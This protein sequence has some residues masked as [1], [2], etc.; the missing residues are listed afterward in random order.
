VRDVGPDGDGGDDLEPGGVHDPHGAHVRTEH[1]GAVADCSEADAMAEPLAT[2]DLGVDGRDDAAQRP[3]RGLERPDRPVGEHR[4]EQR[5]AVGAERRGLG[6]AAEVD[7]AGDQ[8]AR[9]DVVDASQR[10]SRQVV[11][12]E[13]GD[14]IGVGRGGEDAAV[15][16]FEIAARGQIL[17]ACAAWT[18]AP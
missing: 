7:R 1:H 3:G 18:F 14:Q 17:K 9:R 13:V 10:G 8:P 5:V 12:D 15:D 11:V 4:G 6:E 2:V 16:R